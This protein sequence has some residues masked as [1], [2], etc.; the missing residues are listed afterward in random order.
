MRYY[1][2]RAIQI[3]LP[4][5]NYCA[6]FCIIAVR[7]FEKELQITLGA[8]FSGAMLDASRQNITA[9]NGAARSRQLW[10]LVHVDDSEWRHSTSARQLLTTIGGLLFARLPTMLSAPL[11]PAPAVYVITSLFL[12]SPQSKLCSHSVFD[13]VLKKPRQYIKSFP[14][15]TGTRRTDG[16]TCKLRRFKDNM[17]NQNVRPVRVGLMQRVYIFHNWWK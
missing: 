12:Q 16:Q 15:N 4:L 10:K 3:H 2:K 14:Q 8:T 17:S 5:P 1:K 13:C 7:G 11:S 9:W 6:K